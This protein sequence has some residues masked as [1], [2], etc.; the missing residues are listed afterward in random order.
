VLDLFIQALVAACG[1]L[2]MRLPYRRARHFHLYAIAN[3]SSFDTSL[4]K[5]IRLP[6]AAAGFIKEESPAT[7]DGSRIH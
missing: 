6:L 1:G 4:D 5:K 2:Q 7:V 3:R